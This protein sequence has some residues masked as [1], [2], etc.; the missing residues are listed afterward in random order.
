MANTTAFSERAGHSD[1]PQGAEQAHTLIVTVE[2]RPGSVDR[3]VG[4]MRRRRA[5][6][7]QMVL[8]RGATANLLRFT[9]VVN[10]SEV[11][12]DHLVEQLRKVIDVKNIENLSTQEAITR[13]LA[14]ISVVS[15]PTHYNEI[16]TIAETFGAHAIGVSQDSITLEIAGSEERITS[17]TEALHDFGIREIARSGCVAVARNAPIQ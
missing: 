14:L 8:G 10:D 6:M 12:V 11:H 2:D 5:N 4:I 7:Q 9:I 13:E 16:L 15:S 17:L 1:V 3:V